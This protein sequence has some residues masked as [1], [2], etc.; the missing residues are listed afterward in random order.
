MVSGTHTLKLVVTGTKNAASSNYYTEIDRFMVGTTSYQ[1][2]HWRVSFGP[3]QGATST[4]ASGGSYRQSGSTAQAAWFYGFTG[5]YVELI[6]AKGPTRGVATIKVYDAQT[7]ALVKT[8]TPDLYASTVQWQAAVRI[9][10]LD[11]SKK[12]YMKVTSADGTKVVVDTYRAFPNSGTQPSA[13]PGAPEGG[14]KFEPK[15]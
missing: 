7:D 5:P 3:W 1:E 9:D 13:A 10:G 11:S 12:Y 14:G 6:T 15:G 8:V 4:N 2:N